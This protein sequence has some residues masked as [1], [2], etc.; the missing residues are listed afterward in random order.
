LK[1]ISLIFLLLAGLQCHAQRILNPSDTL[2]KPRRNL[3]LG[4]EVVGYSGSLFALQ[5][6][7]YQG[8]QTGG[9]HFFN[10]W[11]GWQ[12]MDKTGHLV[13]NYQICNTVYKFNKWA[14][15]SDSRATWKGAAL[16]TSYQLVVEVM[17]GFSEGWG[18]SWGDIGFNTLGGGSF[19]VQQLAWKEQR[20][21][22]KYS[23]T[24]INYK[25]YT[26][27][28]ERRQRNLYGNTIIEQW[29]KD[30][31]GQTHWVSA[32]I[33][34]LAGK[35]ARF[36]KWLN[37]AVGMSSNNVLGAESNT[38]TDP[39]NEANQITSSLMP[40]RQFIMSFDVDLTRA[41]LP[42]YLNWMKAVFGVIKFPSPAL[43]W[44]SERGFR[45]HA[46]YF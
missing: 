26:A 5:F 8:Y 30:Y 37:V 15:A 46:L 28:E 24:P 9:F 1:K 2:N 35:P 18:F 38:W 21:Q 32:N 25:K 36:P 39:D 29:L 44:N 31:N 42:N 7:W 19:L 43:E 17:D 20:F 34:S 12:Q 45:G 22:F 10:D 16:S 14:G 3:I 23:F 4:T 40:E 6:A 27:Q 13:T 11:P 33:W 41:N